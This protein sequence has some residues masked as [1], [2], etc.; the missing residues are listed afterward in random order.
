VVREGFIL[1]VR[2]Y[3]NEA[4]T[5]GTFS[6][7]FAATLN[8]TIREINFEWIPASF[9]SSLQR[10]SMTFDLVH[11][12]PHRLVVGSVFVETGDL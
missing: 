2:V 9:Y 8:S 11:S 4:M 6:L 12:V 3:Q 7:R 5:V 10:I 1:D